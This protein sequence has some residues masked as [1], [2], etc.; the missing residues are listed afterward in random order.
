MQRLLHLE[1]YNLQIS[2]IQYHV[3]ERLCFPTPF[4]YVLSR[5]QRWR[6]VT[7]ITNFCHLTLGAVLIDRFGYFLSN[8]LIW[9]VILSSI[10]NV[11]IIFLKEHIGK[12][13][14]YN[15]LIF[16]FGYPP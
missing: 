15:H 9:L 4:S 3:P 13:D 10:L 16:R 7:R 8:V 12:G 11:N 6:P 1:L 5:Q 14:S 2:L